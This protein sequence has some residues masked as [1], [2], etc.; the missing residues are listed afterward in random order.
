MVV[1]KKKS[2]KPASR[3]KVGFRDL[4]LHALDPRFRKTVG[5]TIDAMSES[6]ELLYELATTDEK[7]GLYNNQ[8]FSHVLE[9]ELDKAKRGQPL[10]IIAIDIDHFKKINDTYGHLKADDLLHRLSR[11]LERHVRVS[12]VLA[13]FGGEEF[14]ILLPMTTPKRAVTVARRLKKSV[15]EDPMLKKHKLTISGGIAEYKKQD[16]KKRLMTRADKALYKAK[17]NG[18]DQFCVL[19]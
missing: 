18:R 6:I 13:R 5:E 4:R 14:F 19:E 9:M 2:D 15:H 1:K 10:T 12:D 7:T 16:N 3:K 11:V 8:F 17:Q